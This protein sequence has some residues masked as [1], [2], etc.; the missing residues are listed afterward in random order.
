[1][2][3]MVTRYFVGLDLAPPGLPTALAVVGRPRLRPADPA[4]TR[5]VYSLRH[6]HRFPP[7]TPYPAVVDAVVALLRTPPLPFAWLLAD[8]TGVGQAVLDLVRDGLRRG[9]DCTF[10]P[11]VLTAG[12][13]VTIGPVG[14][15]AV[16]KTDLVGTLQV[17]LQTRRLQIATSLPDVATLVRELAAYRAK[18][19]IGPGDALAWR[20]APHDDLV[21]AAALAAWAGERALSREAS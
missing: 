18:V 4:T 9:V 3:S 20:D 5:P 13:T 12:G 14:G 10:S 11:V 17:L 21:L 15:Y 6:L 1:M 19:A 2:A 8:Y 7:G 16:P